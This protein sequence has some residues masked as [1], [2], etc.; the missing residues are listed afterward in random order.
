M[1]NL[2][3]PRVAKSNRKAMKSFFSGIKDL[4]MLRAIF[5]TG[6]SKFAK[7]SLFSGLN[8]LNDLTI[9]PRADQLLGYTDKEIDH[10][11]KPYINQI[12][13]EKE[14][15]NQTIRK[16][17]KEWY[18][19]YR[20]S[21]NPIKVYNPFSVLYFLEK[22]KFSNF[23]FSSGTP[24]FLVNLLKNDDETLKNIRTLELSESGLGAFE[25]Q[26]LPPITLLF[27]TGYLT[28]I[29]YNAKTN[30]YRLGYP[31]REVEESFEKYLFAA[32]SYADIPTVEGAIP[33]AIKA[34]ET[35]HMNL[36]CVALE[37]LF[38]HIPYQ[39]HLHHEAYYHSLFQLLIK[40]LG[41]DAE[42]E[43]CTDKGRIDLV[44]KTKKYIYLFE[45][46][47]NANPKVALAQI[48][49]K[50]YYQKYQL[51]NKTLVLVGLTFNKEKKRFAINYLS[52][53]VAS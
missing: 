18:N 12:A 17:M 38:A 6:V 34:L 1:N 44:L 26:K 22:K 49:N 27:Q 8:N 52:N 2:E 40:M 43:I 5:I 4:K 47:F 16:E 28:I 30:K 7:T 14:I 39:L 19:G 51:S 10:Y 9:D 37:T 20:F 33:Q 36:F 29:D 21:E 32:F 41:L 53:T 35:N 50:K 31:N 46:K 45:V 48:E 42:S 13:K 15:E 23:W 25:I 24:T 3:V 11:L